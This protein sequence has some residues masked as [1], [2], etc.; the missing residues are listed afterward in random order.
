MVLDQVTA[1]RA[2]DETG[3]R[4]GPQ[5][6]VGDDDQGRSLGQAVGDRAD[7]QVV[8]EPQ[9]SGERLLL[10]T[11]IDVP[12]EPVDDIRAAGGAPARLGKRQDAPREDPNEES[13]LRQR[14]L[15]EHGFGIDGSAD[16]LRPE[17]ACARAFEQ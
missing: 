7:Q 3:K 14:K 15:Q 16:L 17:R 5:D 11:G 9:A 12:G 1:C 13:V 10:R 6:A 8:E 2:I 4:H